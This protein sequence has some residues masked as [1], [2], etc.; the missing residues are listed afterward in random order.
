MIIGSELEGAYLARAAHDEGLKVLMLDP[1]EKVG[2]QLLQGQ[3]LY[4]DEPTD[5]AGNT[6]LQGQVKTLF[7]EFKRGNIRKLEEFQ[8]YV[9]ELLS[10]IPIQSG[11]EIVDVQMNQGERKEVKALTYKKSSGEIKTI[12]AKYWVENTDAAYLS[13]RLSDTR[14]PGVET[15]FKVDGKAYM[16]S[17][18]MMK[19]KGVD[20]KRFQKEVNALDDSAKADKYGAYTFVTDTFT[21]GFGKVGGSFTP[22]REDIFLRGLNILNQG[23]GEALINALL[24]HNV[25]PTDEARVQEAVALGK[26]ETERVLLHLQQ[27]LPGW[28]EAAINDFPDYLYIR[29]YDRY[30]TEYV[31]TAA[32]L[33]SGTM[34]W[35]NVSIGGYPLDIQGIQQSPW[36][37]SLGRPDQYGMPLRSFMLKDYANVV[38]AGKNVGASAPAYGSARIQ[39]NTA[40]AGEVI[41]IMLGQINGQK[42]LLDMTEEEMAELQHYIEKKYDIQLVSEGAV[43]KIKDYSKEELK[44]IIEHS[45]HLR[46]GGFLGCCSSR[47]KVV[48][49]FF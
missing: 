35:D 11:I 24:I 17:S 25:E 10:G 44:L 2:G 9:D 4:L 16:A 48:A 49:I 23:D 38:V 39:A 7:Q 1:R 13:S 15:I 41:G 30:E 26:S 42:S 36:G 46:G 33:L 45:R 5:D 31:L 34:F 12:Q 3:M 27:K 37:V 28:E 40:L 14:I 8:V 6:L 47:N 32:D 20:W 21:W 43:N 19:F 29:D 18:L 22:S